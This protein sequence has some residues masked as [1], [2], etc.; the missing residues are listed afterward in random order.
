[1]A[2]NTRFAYNIHDILY[3][4]SDIDLG[5]PSVFRV[6]ATHVKPDLIVCIA[7]TTPAKSELM[8]LDRI[9]RRYYGRRNKGFVLDI[10]PLLHGRIMVGLRNLCDTP[11]H[12]EVSPLFLRLVKRP[13]GFYVLPLLVHFQA[14]LD[15]KLVQKGYTLIHACCLK[16]RQGHGMLF[17]GLGGAGKSSVATFALSIDQRCSYLSDDIVITDGRRAYCFPSF[18]IPTKLDKLIN[19]LERFLISTPKYDQPPTNELTNSRVERFAEIKEIFFLESGRTGITELAKDEAMEKIAITKECGV[20]SYLHNSLLMA[21][22]YFNP[23][24]NVERLSFRERAI[25]QQL[26]EQSRI[27][28][29]K[30]KSP[31]DLSNLLREIL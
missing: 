16:G 1:M 5:L 7:R 12:F 8:K 29:L 25:I 20:G 2:K 23:K 15:V 31:T 10:L 4:E 27:Y 21:Y 14:L 22:R 6:Q 24:D 17:T 3:I 13:M 9:G 30:F 11:S 19:R 26:L 18:E 28:R